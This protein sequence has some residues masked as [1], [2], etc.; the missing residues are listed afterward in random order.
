MTSMQTLQP[1]HFDWLWH[2][3]VATI[4]LHGPDRK[5]P[6]TF[7]SY[8]ELR[9][10]FRSLAY[11]KDVDAV[12]LASNEGNFCSGGDVHDIIG[13]LVGMDMKG[14]RSL[15]WNFDRQPQHV[16]A[17]VAKMCKMA[18]SPDETPTAEDDHLFEC[19]LALE[20]GEC[21]GLSFPTY[22]P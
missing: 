4:R 3:R 10:C 1:A 13:P 21:C 20:N 22:R 9:D 12:I 15:A 17:V 14:L 2:D 19:R 6:L 16:R 8:A 7:E 5:N 11:A 18:E